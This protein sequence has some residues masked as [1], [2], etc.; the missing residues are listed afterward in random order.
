MHHTSQHPHF[1]QCFVKNNHV[2]G[3]R[4]ILSLT[5]VFL[6]HQSGVSETST[7]AT[8]HMGH[9]CHL[10]ASARNSSLF[11]ASNVGAPVLWR[12]L[13]IVTWR[14]VDCFY[15]PAWPEVPF[16]ELWSSSVLCSL[17]L[18]LV[19]EPQWFITGS[20]STA[21]ELNTGEL[22]AVL[23]RCASDPAMSLTGPAPRTA[24][25]GLSKRL[26]PHRGCLQHH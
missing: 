24:T 14:I 12:P 9:G 3:S 25:G 2:T 10:V 1:R 18:F 8:R 5:L 16:L 4:L 13:L 21:A 20:S 23:K 6:H 17:V 19:S 7:Q 11:T 26:H 22:S 15:S